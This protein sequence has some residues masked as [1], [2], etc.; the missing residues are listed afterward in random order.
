LRGKIIPAFEA[1][2]GPGFQAMLMVDNSQGY[3]M[4]AE[5]ALVISRMNVRPGGKQAKMHDTWFMKN[6]LRVSQTMVFP[7]NHADHPNEPKGMQEVLKEQGLYPAG[8]HKKCKKCPLIDDNCCCKT[9]LAQRPDFLAQKSLVQ[10]VVEAAGHLC[11]FL[12]KFHRKLNF[13]ELFWGAV[14][15]YLWDN[16]DCIFNT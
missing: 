1:A 4:Y 3:S 6:G 11:I 8:L 14:K 12:P 16:C 9:I 15:K 2:H 5:N 7:L 13:I 10:E